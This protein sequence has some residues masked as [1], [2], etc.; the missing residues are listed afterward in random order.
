MQLLSNFQWLILVGFFNLNRN[1]S[2]ETSKLSPLSTIR[3]KSIMC[4]RTFKIYVCSRYKLNKLRSFNVYENLH[5]VKLIPI[6]WCLIVIKLDMVDL[7]RSN[8][9]HVY[10]SN[11]P[12]G[13]STCLGALKLLNNFLSMS[14]FTYYRREHPILNMS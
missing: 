14:M 9:F 11:P 6:Y 8:S 1:L 4:A 13:L 12:H 3:Y 2:L 7:V 10:T 5:C